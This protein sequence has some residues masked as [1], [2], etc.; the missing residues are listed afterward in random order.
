M[1]QVAIVEDDAS[2][3]EKIRECLNY[4]S[5]ENQILFDIHEFSSGFSFIGQYVPGFDIVFMDP[6]YRKDIEAD[7]LSYLL[8]SSIVKEGTLIIVQTS[9]DTDVSYMNE[10]PCVVERIKDYKTNRHVF[11]RV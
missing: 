8:E 10:L 1:I 2:A 11:L 4:V 3:R 9:L 6:P 5:A 7:V